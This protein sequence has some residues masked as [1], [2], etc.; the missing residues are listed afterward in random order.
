MK[1]RHYLLLGLA[2]MV[3]VGV[4]LGTFLAARVP[5][6]AN[7]SGLA[8][9]YLAAQFALGSNDLAQAGDYLERALET[10]PDDPNLLQSAMRARLVGGRVPQAVDIAQTLISQTPDNQQAGLLLAIAAFEAGRYSSAERYLSKM[11]KGPMARLLEPNIRLWMAIAENNRDAVQ[12]AVSQLRRSAAFTPISMLQV[13]QAMELSG[14]IQG[15]SEAYETGL[16][17]G[18]ASYFFFVKAYGGYLERQ[19]DVD[20]AR[21]LYQ[22]Y[23]NTH[24]THPHVSAALA[25]LNAAGTPAPPP[26]LAR[27]VRV[28]LAYAFYAVAEV[29]ERE[30]RLELALAYAHLALFLEPESD[31]AVFMTAEIFA[32]HERWTAAGD[33]FA[34]IAPEQV[35]YRA[36]QIKRAEML[37]E[38]D[39]VEEAIS[40]LYAVM[41]NTSDD[42]DV[43][44]ALG[45][46][47][48]FRFRF[49]EAEQAYDKAI[50]FIREERAIYWHVYFARGIT[51]ER[52]GNWVMAEVDLQKARQLSG[53]EPHVLNYLGYSWI[54]Q[55]IYLKEGL[56]IIELAVRKEPSN[57]FFVDSLG[58]AHYQ[59]GQYDKALGYLEHASR[60]EPTDA[61]ITEHLGDVLWQL[62]RE[63]EARY[64]W[65]KALAFDPV[66]ED[67][68]KIESK[69]I[70]GLEIA[71]ELGP[72]KL[73]GGTEI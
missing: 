40:V 13:G 25:R 17:A 70:T 31:I 46:M 51:R 52:Q 43:L 73:S 24:L 21:N 41:T 47:L 48:R 69:I 38:V 10:D 56:R 49:E 44:V 1:L 2:G 26:P 58:W 54:D 12:S 20:A 64:Q 35:M 27:N 66:D 60:L 37:N 14:D 50:G 53:D 72:E 55:G 36:A 39:A 65:R 3:V 15:A 11:N 63:V 68:L 59:L 19:G 32:R 4:A 30:K 28:Q 45:D 34:L 8:G 18:G 33:R 7:P 16:R 29:M 57:G 61:V 5:H 67:R 62:G 23:H 6:Y 71:P 42:I 9:A 22:D